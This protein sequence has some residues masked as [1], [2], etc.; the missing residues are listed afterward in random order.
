M[1][2]FTKR[3]PR[4]ISGFSPARAATGAA[5]AARQARRIEPLERR[6]LL[7][8]AWETVDDYQL[9]AGQNAFVRPM[10]SDP[11]GDVFAAGVAWD[12]TNYHHII[13]EKQNGV[14]GWT[15]VAEV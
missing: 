9:V 10:T 5:A 14:P 3:L 6:M 2:A 12:P 15:T 13:R 8:A 1:R 4:H 11:A 7:S